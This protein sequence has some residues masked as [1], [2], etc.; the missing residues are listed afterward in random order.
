MSK[1]RDKFKGSKEN[2]LRKYLSLAGIPFEMGVTIYIMA[3]LGNQ[4][5]TYFNTKDE[6]FKVILVMLGIVISIYLVV[7]R[8]NRINKLESNNA[9]NDK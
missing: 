7:K 5:D 6:M 4:L 8:L 2:Q 9:K 3:Y 1:K